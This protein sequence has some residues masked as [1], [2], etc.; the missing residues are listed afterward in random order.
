MQGI[1]K[2]AEI[3][4]GIAAK[5][6]KSQ[7][8]HTPG[9]PLCVDSDNGPFKTIQDAIDYA[10]TGD[11]ILVAPGL[12]MKNLIVNKPDLT[13]S[14]KDKNGD[15]TVMCTTGALVTFDLQ[16]GE[17][18][19]ING[20]KFN[21]SGAEDQGKIGD[22]E[23][24]AREKPSG[25]FTYESLEK[26]NPNELMKSICFVK[27]GEV[28]LKNC[29]LFLNYLISSTKYDIPAVVSLE[30]SS[31]TLEQCEIKGNKSHSTIGIIAIKS[32]LSVMK[33]RIH[34]HQAGGIVIFQDD[35]RTVF[36]GRNSEIDFNG[37]VGI[38]CSGDR[39]AAT[40][41]DC[42]IESNDGPGIFVGM[43]NNTQIKGNDI[44]HN[45]T[46][47]EIECADPYVYHNTVARNYGTGI[48]VH[49]IELNPSIPRI[50]ANKVNEN[51]NGIECRGEGCKPEIDNNPEIKSNRKAGVRV[52]DCAHAK[53]MRNSIEENH[54]QGVL[55]VENASANVESNKI[56]GN[57]K[58]NV[59]FGGARS[60]NTTVIS[61]TITDSQF[62]GIFIIEGGDTRVKKNKIE[63]NLDGIVMLSSTVEVT[64]NHVRK[65]A[66]YGVLIAKSGEFT[67]HKCHPIF[68]GNSVETNGIAGIF[69]KAGCSGTITGNLSADNPVQVALEKREPGLKNIM[70]TNKFDGEVQIPRSDVCNIF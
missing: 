63:G 41:E 68:T 51:D 28:T 55:V 40:I 64:D 5:K 2:S 42:R 59:A 19:T 20:I 32:D 36:V 13:I 15:I 70:N 53:V 47:I 3:H 45:R 37:R 60:E 27:G 31:M 61:N 6:S 62:E 44:R 8:D 67:E 4:T 21:H 35:A 9:E 57:M 30:D 11:T 54:T 17:S 18:C 43:D 58:A 50:Q 34:N 33:S 65:N 29:R 49:S 39:S 1:I 10:Q 38:L 22:C 56:S 48:Y 69:I 14:P 7:L 25:K 26:F 52:A 46:G 12:Y 16:Q 24:N 23:P 66:R